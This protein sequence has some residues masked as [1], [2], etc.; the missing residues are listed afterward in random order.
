MKRDLH[1]MLRKFVKRTKALTILFHKKH[2][3]K[4]SKLKYVLCF[5]PSLINPDDNH[6]Y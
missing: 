4:T 2:T 5:L 1:K 6:A 3:G